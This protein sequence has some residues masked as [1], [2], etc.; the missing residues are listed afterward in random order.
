MKACSL[1]R[2][3]ALLSSITL[4][5]VLLVLIVSLWGRGEEAEGPRGELRVRFVDSETGQT[6][7]VRVAVLDEQEQAFVA[8]DALLAGG[9]P[10][11]QESRWEGTVEDALA[12]FKPSWRNY[13]SGTTQFYSGGESLLRLPSGRYRV[14]ASKGIEY[15]K[16]SREVSI[17]ADSDSELTVEIPRWINMPQKG[18]YSADPHIHVARTHRE[19][20]P[21]ISKWMQAEDVHVAT[22]L[23]WGNVTAFHNAPQYAFGPE[24]V[25][26]E[27]IYLLASGQENPRTHVFG[28][29]ITLGTAEPVNFPDQYLIYQLFWEEAR[30][31]GGLSGYAHMGIQAGAQNGL[32][33]DLPLNLISFL[34][35]LQFNGADF[36][37]WYSVLNSG[38]KMSPTAGS[39][40]PFGGAPIGRERF[41]TRVEGPLTYQKW[42]DGIEQGRTFVSNGPLLEFTVNDR[43]LG[44]EVVLAEPGNVS[45]KALVRFDTERDLVEKMELVSNGQIIRTFLA[46]DGASEIRSDFELPVGEAGWVALRASGTKLGMLRP[47]SSLAHTAPVYLAVHGRPS[48]AEHPRAKSLCLAWAGRLSELEGRL[49][50]QFEAIA[51]SRWD[52]KISGE[53]VLKQREE[54][55]KKVRS[56]RQYFLTRAGL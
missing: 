52:E 41:Y 2:L 37:V 31:Q 7:P 47:V 35:V 54:L 6:T 40:Y 11:N 43:G 29:T 45:I 17:T 8:E 25:Y 16:V 9:D 51:L 18:W 14:T 55:L 15:G 36:S 50:S 49:R 56:A 22:L 44:E 38:F 3:P 10:K 48:R 53:Y 32:S 27:G 1:R 19:L 30:R 4:T 26:N 28:H 33:I 21:L 24:S 23:Q 5:L 42:L 39:D 20:D 13:D 46:A 34:E 12:R